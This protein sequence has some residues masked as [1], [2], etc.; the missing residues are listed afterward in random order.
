MQYTG[1]KDKNGVE[2]YEGDIVESY[3]QLCVVTFNGDNFGGV[4]GWNLILPNEEAK[5]YY[6]GESPSNR[7]EIVG[8]IYDN[9]DLWE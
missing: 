6:Y 5:E 8:N 4:I 2:I 9:S 1:V 7:N 3:N